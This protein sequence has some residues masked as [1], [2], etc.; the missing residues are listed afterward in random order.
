MV[1]AR[2]KKGEHRATLSF[3]HCEGFGYVLLV[4]GTD[5]PK[6]VKAQI[7]VSKSRE[8]KDLFNSLLRVLVGNGYKLIE[9]K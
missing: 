6:T 9:G 5:D 7:E 4:S 1:K 2:L 8:S 3:V